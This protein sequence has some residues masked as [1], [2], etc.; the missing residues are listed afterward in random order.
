M[1]TNPEKQFLSNN[2]PANLKGT[3]MSLHRCAIACA[4]FVLALSTEIHAEG[5][6]LIPGEFGW[7]RTLPLEVLFTC[8]LYPADRDSR[9]TG[10]RIL[11][12]DVVADLGLSRDA[13]QKIEQLHNQI[14]A[15]YDAERRKVPKEDLNKEPDRGLF[16]TVRNRH[17]KEFDDLLTPQQQERLDQIHLQTPRQITDALSDSGVANAVGLTEAQR[18][19]IHQLHWEVSHAE[20]LESGEKA[21]GDYTGPSAKSL[22]DACPGKIMKLL[23][24]EQRQKFEKLRGAPFVRAQREP[25]QTESGPL[26]RLSGARMLAQNCWKAS[27]SPDG[28]R[29]VVGKMPESSGLRIVEVTT[30]AARDLLPYGKDP[31]WSPGDGRLIA[32][33]HHGDEGDE[34]WIVEAGG[35]NPRKLALGGFPSWSPDAKSVYFQSRKHNRLQIIA[36]DAKGGNATDAMEMAFWHPSVSPDGRQ[37]TYRSGNQ[38]IIADLKTGKAVKAFPIDVGQGFAAGWSPDGKQIGYGGW[39]GADPV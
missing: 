17:R 8:R 28:N 36:V 21:T 29:I 1:R 16:Y 38:I 20:H 3:L 19:Q 4:V 27:F 37:V 2:D 6:Y 5:I 39:G 32:F 35:A 18:S 22:Y 25:A 7:G 33:E 15:E 10:E 12:S 11:D 31:A 13:A 34:V 30:G 26:T 14:L 9:I 24:D 23:S